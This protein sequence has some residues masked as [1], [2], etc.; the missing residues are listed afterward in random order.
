MCFGLGKK[1]F[2]DGLFLHYTIQKVGL[3]YLMSLKEV[4][5]AH[6]GNIFFKSKDRT[7]IQIL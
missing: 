7:V 1:V 6:Q 2:C 4:S 3:R 5:Y